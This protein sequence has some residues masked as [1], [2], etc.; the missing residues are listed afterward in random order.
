MTADG[1]STALA[2]P[3]VGLLDVH[4][5]LEHFAITTFAVSPEAMARHLAP[6][7]EPEVFQL[8]AGPRAFVSAV[9]FLDSR[10][11]FRLLPW[12]RF[13]FGQ[14]N[15]RAYVLRRGQRAA[16]FFGTSLDSLFVHVPRLVWQM[17]WHRA[18]MRFDVTYDGDRCRRYRLETTGAG[19][20]AE[21]DL[22]GS[23]EP[24]GA[25]DGFRDAAETAQVLTA[26][27]EGYFARRGGRSSHYAIWHAPLVMQRARAHAARFQLF[28]DLGLIEPGA[29]PHSVLVQRAT[30][31]AIY[32]PP[33]L[34]ID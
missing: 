7:F 18:R 20:A 34:V 5:T 12:P 26:P 10:F 15:Y 21:L 24:T 3:S 22:E 30:D 9:T 23:G 8:A 1:S 32:L 27:T 16:W 33:R 29:A 4:V 11:R 14:T 6:G 25:L 28:E 19:A 2:M 31:Y 13:S 17:P